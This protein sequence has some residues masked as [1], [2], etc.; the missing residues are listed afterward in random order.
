MKLDELNRRL[1]LLNELSSFPPGEIPPSGLRSLSIYGG[2][3]GIFIDKEKTKSVSPDGLGVTVSV[4]HTGDFYPAELS[5]DGLIYHYPNTNR[6]ISRDRNEVDATKN[7]MRLGLP[8]FVI[9]NGR[10]QKFRSFKLGW[11]VDFDDKNEVF[12]IEFSDEKPVYQHIKVD[13]EFRLVEEK[14]AKLVHSKSRPDQRRFRYDVVKNYGYKCFV[15][16]ASHPKVLEAAHIRSKGKMGSDDWR[17]GMILCRNHHAAFDN[18]LFS[19]NPET[20]DVCSISDQVR[21]QINLEEDKLNSLTGRFPHPD[22]LEWKW[23]KEV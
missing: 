15:C 2:A 3:Q 4:L 6:P 5:D 7:A 22:A 11:V 23:K 14:S 21:K 12:L 16:S 18:G 19:I 9:L 20:L 13:D 1:E 8:I 17:N 10:T